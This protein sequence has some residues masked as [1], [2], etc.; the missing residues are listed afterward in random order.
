MTDKDYVAK[1]NQEVNAG[2]GYISDAS[3]YGCPEYW[4][5]SIRG[6]GDCE[7][8]ALGKFVRLRQ[9]GVPLEALRLAIVFTETAEGAARAVAKQGGDPAAMGDHAV[10]VVRCVDGDY[11]LDNRFPHLVD[12]LSLVGY[13]LDR[14]WN[15]ST[16]R[17][18]HGEC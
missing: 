1:V 15:H 9:A 10:L 18:E 7:D 2:V 16:N 17:W 11:I 6:F 14:I 4:Q 3:Q 13:K 8:Y 5:V 12:S